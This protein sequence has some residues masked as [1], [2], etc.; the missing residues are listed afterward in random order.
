MSV[1]T[2]GWAKQQVC[3]CPYAKAVLIELANWA[4]AD[5]IC[6]F[7]RVT[8]IARVVEISERSVQRALRLLEAPKAEGGRGLIRRV[9]RL[10]RD[11]G[12]QANCF[13]LVGF[14]YPGDQQSP[15]SRIVESIGDTQSPPGCPMGGGGGD[16]PVTPYRELEL[17][18]IDSPQSP[19]RLDVQ[20]KPIAEDWSAPAIDQL[21]STAW[22]LAEQWPHGAYEAEAEAFHQHW[23][24]RGDRRANWDAQWSARI[25]LLHPSVM[26]AGK[27]GMRFCASLPSSGQGCRA[28]QDHSPVKALS[29]ETDQSAQLRKVLRAAVSDGHWTN[30]LSP[31]AYQ[32]DGARLKVAVRSE[33]MRNW[34]ETNFGKVILAAAQRLDPAV[35]WVCVEASWPQKRNCGVLQPAQTRRVA[36]PAHNVNAHIPASADDHTREHVK[37]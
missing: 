21:P 24:G 34:V 16:H 31:A 1:E 9:A 25:P 27:A 14:I 37:D 33:F 17:N 6:E 4:R 11:G 8:D 35:S 20:R 13:E 18:L 3:G 23:L 22:E 10:R 12:Q 29:L 36:V 28:L 5:G 32:F 19:P 26:R 2:M 15:P 7:R 30:Y